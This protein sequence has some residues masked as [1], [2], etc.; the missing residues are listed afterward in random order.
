MEGNPQKQ[1]KKQ[2]TAKRDDTALHSAARSGDLEVVLEIINGCGEEQLDELLSKQN[3]S[4]ETTLYVA[5]ECGHVEL[6]EEM[7]KYYDVGSAALKA[8][9][10][11]DAFHIAAKFGKL[12]E[13]L[14]IF[15]RFLVISIGVHVEVK[16]YRKTCM[17]LEHVLC[18]VA[19]SDSVERGEVI[20]LLV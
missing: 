1:V 13:Y 11:F 7:M 16:I 10:G 18:F 3:Q 14:F 2:L 20:Y 17:I 9:N 6:V 4:G 15:S 19:K 5:A 12:G 8:K